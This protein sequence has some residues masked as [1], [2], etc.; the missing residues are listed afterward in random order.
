MT[1]NQAR[2]EWKEVPFSARSLQNFLGIDADTFEDH[3]KLIYEGNVDITLRVFDHFCGLCHFHRGSLMRSCDHYLLIKFVHL[4]SD[5]G[6]TSAGN[7]FDSCYPVLLITRVDAFG[8]ISAEEVL[9]KLKATYL[10]KHRDA[11]LLSTARINGTFVDNDITFFEY[12]SDCLAGT[13]EG[14]EIR[15][16]KLVYRSRNCNNKIISLLQVF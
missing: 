16:L 14:F 1:S 3:G 5:L 4:L 13:L 2:T 12:A 7:F 9:I 11:D 10:F 8:R 6:S 15:R